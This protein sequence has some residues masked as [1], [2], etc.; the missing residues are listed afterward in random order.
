MR[1][2]RNGKCAC[3]PLGVGFR[4]IDPGDL[5]KLAR[6]E[7][8]PDGLSNSKAIARSATSRR[9]IDFSTCPGE[10][11]AVDIIATSVFY[12]GRFGGDPQ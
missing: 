2:T 4:R 5:R 9:L 8:K 1:S 12:A 10:F 11:A 3:V 6:F 7:H